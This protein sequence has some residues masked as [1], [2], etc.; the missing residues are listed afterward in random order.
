[1]FAEE[2]SIAV[3]PAP[4][5]G[6]LRALLRVVAARPFDAA[7]WLVLG[8]TLVVVLATF[9]QYGVA[10]DEQGETVFGT[11]LLKYYASGFHDHSAFDFV[12]FRFYG[13]G[14]ELPA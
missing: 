13:A 9:R 6:A 1:M 10:W 2:P 8:A 3:A 14:F 11:L 4:R 5:E 12:N 7:A